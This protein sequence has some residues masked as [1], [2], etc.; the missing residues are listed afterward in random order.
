MKTVFSN[1]DLVHTFNQQNQYEGRTSTG[2]MHFYGRKLYSYGSH[3]LLCEFIDNNTVMIND[4]GY[5]NSTTKHIYHVARATE[6]R[7]QFFVKQ[8]DIKIV[9]VA[10]K[11]L[12]NKLPRATKK[13]DFYKVQIVELYKKYIEWLT[14]SKTLT[15]AKKKKEHRETVK[16]YAKFEYLQKTYK[17]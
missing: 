4:I 7:K 14:Y 6:N 11:E 9:N 17:I 15:S 1:S 16:L 3:Y 8:S 12:I 2:D 5:G 10:I 13:K